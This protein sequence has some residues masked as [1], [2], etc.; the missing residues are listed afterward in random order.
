MGEYPPRSLS[1]SPPPP[2]PP[3]PRPLSYNV[4]F[5]EPDDILPEPLPSVELI[6]DSLHFIN[7][8]SARSTARV[9]ESF[10]VKYGDRVKPIE[11]ENMR[12]VREQTNIMV[13][14]VFAVY[15]RSIGS[16]KDITYIVME[17]IPG[18]TLEFLWNKLSASE[19]LNIASQLQKAFT[20]LRA[21]PHSGFFGGLG[22]SKLM[23][24]VF[25]TDEPIPTINGP[26]STEDELIQGMIERYLQDCGTIMQQKADYYSRVLPKVLRGSDKPVFTYAKFKPN[27]VIIRPGG[28][29][30]IVDWATAGW[31]PSYWEYGI[32]MFACGDWKDDWH[33]YVAEILEEF[34]SHYVWVLMLRLDMWSYA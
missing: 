26:F 18:D 24:V 5:R 3:I 13:P 17:H 28:D 6:E 7:Q 9:G 10:V 33:A 25:R 11:A 31:Y 1:L 34:P 30:V 15:Q 19:K 4:L 12:F 22:R 29:V 23:D 21:I 14:R 2:P 27:N 16:N 32:S 8:L 20:S